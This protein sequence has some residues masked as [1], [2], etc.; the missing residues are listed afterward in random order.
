M[1]TDFRTLAHGNTI[2]EAGDLLL[3]TSQQD[4]PV[5]HGDEVIGL[6]TRSALMRAMLRDGPEAYVAGAMD[7]NFVRVPPEMDLATALPQLSTAGAM[8]LVMDSDRLVG[9][10]TAE[11]LYEF[12]LLRQ[13]SLARSSHHES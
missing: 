13:V 7:R 4:F 3:S 1:I 12:I 6:L 2:R 8:A 5:M 11:N 9:M 10:L